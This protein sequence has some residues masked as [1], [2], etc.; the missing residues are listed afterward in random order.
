M[1]REAGRSVVG[2]SSEL[3]LL[4]S[5]LEQ[6][7]SRPAV[8]IL[9][10]PAGIGKTTLCRAVAQEAAD[11]GFSVLTATGAAAEAS[12]SCSVLADLI[13]GFDNAALSGLSA[14]HQRALQTLVTGI[15]GPRHD[16][17]L[18][19][20]AFRTALARQ[21]DQRPLLIVIDDAH[22]LDEASK[23]ALG[24]AVRRLAGPVALVASFRT[25]EPGTADQSWAQP[26]DPAAL[27]RLTVGPL[28]VGSVTTLVEEHLCR[29]PPRAALAR[30]HELSLGNP[31]YALELARALSDQPV[32]AMSSLPPTLSALVRDRIGDTD[33]A[34]GEA[35]L[36]AAVA[37]APT[38]DLVAA[39][40]GRSAADLVEILGPMEKRGVVEF[41]GPRI[42]FSHPL[43]ASVITNEAEPVT[44][45]RAHRRLADVVTNPEQRARHLALSSP[46]SDAETLAALDAAAEAAAARGTYSTAAELV[47]LAIRHGGD[48][49]LRRLRGGEFLFRTGSLEEADALI[50]PIVEDLPAGPLRTAGLLLVAA[51]RGY[52][53]G[54]AST[55][56]MLERAVAEAGDELVLRTQALIVLALSIGI[57][58]DMATCVRYARRARVDA[59]K[60]G[61]AP[62]RCQ[63][64]TLW[65]HVSFMYGLG[66]DFDAL[67]EATNIGKADESAPIMLRPL[68]IRA[69]HWAWTGRLE[70][71]HA[72]LIDISLR[73]E[74]RGNELDVL[75]AAEQLTMIETSLG[76]YGDAARTAAEAV[77]RA[78]LIGGQLPMITARTAEANAAAHQGRLEDAR[79]AAERAV[80]AAT[81]ARLGYLVRPPLISL[82]FALVSAGRYEEALKALQPLL[83]EFDPDHDTEIMA[84]GYLPDAVEAL[85]AT[86]RVAEAAPLV[87]ALEVN[88][89]RL[90]RPWMLAVGARCRALVLAASGDLEGALSSAEESMHHHDRLPMPFER[91]RTELLLGQ[92]LR[93]RRRARDARASLT[94]AAA[95][96]EEIGSPLWAA[97]AQRELAG[98]GTRSTDTVLTETERRVAEGAAA[99]LTNKAIASGLFLSAKTVEMHLSSAYRKLGIRSRAQ[100]AA[101][102]QHGD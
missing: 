26:G 73:C 90:E 78:R 84:G 92:L 36:A 9:D 91:A 69:L 74:E 102:L 58:G 16:E 38:L 4:R 42:R 37:F 55:I 43:I 89:A 39:A 25:G 24:F 87:A 98:L 11:S 83:K 5:L 61:L 13:D 27:T 70:E 41:D 44:R 96:F 8:L 7:R 75:W 6:A 59:D 85:T 35:M 29:T 32:A 12:L 48:T 99:G 79:E 54:L 22:W 30:I 71:A 68:P 86:G 31:F 77:E 34:T 50:A 93:R 21:A 20:A 88:G 51:V 62:L 56:G 49:Y 52:R 63:A 82:A 2:R 81:A 57:G 14:L 33:T 94:R 47:G 101:R 10:G 28:S 67:Q 72:E 1:G 60:T 97:R 80:E 3:E 17:R 18:V 15:D 95:T 46:N 66:T 100:L 45:R 53:D 65:A 23:L 40:T 76:R 64:M 19:A